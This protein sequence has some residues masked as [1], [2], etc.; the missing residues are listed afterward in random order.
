MYIVHE[1]SLTTAV[2]SKQSKYL[3]T[4]YPEID[5]VIGDDLAETLCDSSHFDCTFLFQSSPLLDIHFNMILS[6][7]ERK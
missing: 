7:W 2:L 4:E 1:S 5:T 6:F 3:P